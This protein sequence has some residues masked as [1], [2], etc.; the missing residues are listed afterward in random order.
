MK[1]VIVI[2]L[3]LNSAYLVS[4][5]KEQVRNAYGFLSTGDL[6]N[7][8]KAI[9]EASKNPRIAEHP[10]TLLY[11]S[12]IYAGFAL[13][14]N[15]EGDFFK[16][17]NTGMDAYKKA[18]ENNKDRRA[19]R[20]GEIQD[21]RD[22]LYTAAYNRGERAYKAGNL[23]AASKYFQ[24]TLGLRP[25]DVSLNLLQAVTAQKAGDREEAARAYERL[26]GLGYDSALVYRNLAKLYIEQ[27]KDSL[28]INVIRKGLKKHPDSEGLIFDETDFIIE[29]G[30]GMVE[31]IGNLEKATKLDPSNPTV[32]YTLGLAYLESGAVMRA[33]NALKKTVELKNDH[34]KAFYHL[35]V[36]HYNVAARIINNANE[37][38]RFIDK[39]DY[40]VQRQRYLKEL[41]ESE[42]Y[43]EMA[44]DINPEYV[45]L[46]VPMEEVYTRLGERTKAGRIKAELYLLR[47]EES[48]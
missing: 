13:D 17:L 5:Q 22:R 37:K 41:Q 4:A 10:R 2:F 33:D 23:N 48:H 30:E 11:K 32:W 40:E 25:K 8:K 42:Y 16:E 20:E 46:L 44:Y 26:I 14:T 19:V 12:Y 6:E 3:L 15:R 7:A 45:S 31:A 9:D 43:F 34:Y 21:A 24:F 18:V 39:G 28:G 1:W 38:S 36:L 47:L 29:R 27:D 35:G